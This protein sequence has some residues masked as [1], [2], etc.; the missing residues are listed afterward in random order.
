MMKLLQNRVCVK[1]KYWVGTERDR[2]C[3]NHDCI[4]VSRLMIR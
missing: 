3:V 2:V 4:I 1:C